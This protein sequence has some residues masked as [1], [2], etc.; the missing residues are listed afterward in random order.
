MVGVACPI[1][2]ANHCSS[3]DGVR[4]LLYLEL[5]LLLIALPGSPCQQAPD[6]QA[7]QASGARGHDQVVHCECL[8]ATECLFTSECFCLLVECLFACVC[9][10]LIHWA[11]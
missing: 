7:E 8:L 1:P 10:C 4:E 6:H 3:E 2:I 5:S 11:F 9:A